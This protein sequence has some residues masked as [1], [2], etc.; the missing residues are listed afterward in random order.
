VNRDKQRYQPIAS[1]RVGPALSI[2]RLSS[3]TGLDTRSP[4]PD[5]SI[6]SLSRPRAAYDHLDCCSTAPRNVGSAGV[7]TV[8]TNSGHVS[9]APPPVE[10]RGEKLQ[11]EVRRGQRGRLARDRGG[12]LTTLIDLRRCECVIAKYR[13][14][15]R[16]RETVVKLV[17]SRESIW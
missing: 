10:G 13:Y 14:L 7:A 1:R 15:E 9:L 3:L 16:E 12:Y 8:R 5:T 17:S 4:L 2:H 6:V 11:R